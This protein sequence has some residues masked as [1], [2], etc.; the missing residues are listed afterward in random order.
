MIVFNPTKRQLDDE[1]TRVIDRYQDQ[2]D[3]LV[4]CVGGDG[5]LLGA[6]IIYPGVPKLGVR[7]SKV[8]HHCHPEPKIE[9]TLELIKQGKLAPRE[10][11]KLETEIGREKIMALNEISV[12]STDPRVALRFRYQVNGQDSE[13]IVADGIVVATVFGA[14]GY[15][16]SITQVEYEV[17]MGIGISNPTVPQIHRVVNDASKVMITIDR[18]PGRV[19]ADNNQDSWTVES[20]EQIVIRKS[21][22]KALIY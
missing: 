9:E 8:C 2:I 5:S 7:V 17:G 14:S 15:F 3:N 16:K 6:E 13:E 20:G 22:Q 11:Y 12:M 10:F 21:E 18:G 19:Y 4:V 1:R